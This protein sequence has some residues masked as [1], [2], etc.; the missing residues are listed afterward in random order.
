MQ[1]ISDLRAF[2]TT[3][4]LSSYDRANFDRFLKAIRFSFSVPAIHITGTNG[5][6]STLNYLKSIYMHAGYKVGTFMSPYFASMNEMIAVDGQPINDDDVL[7]L[8]TPR[9][10]TSLNSN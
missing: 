6:G 9:R 1:S 5:K 2:F 7:R 10:R 3:R 8:L 4:D